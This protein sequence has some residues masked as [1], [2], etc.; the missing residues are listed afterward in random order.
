MI[1][2]LEETERLARLIA[3]RRG[4]SPE[5][6]VRDAVREHARAHGLDAP[7]RAGA[8]DRR[9]VDAITRRCASRPLRDPRSARAIL[10]EVWG[11]S[12]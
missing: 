8:M 3:A 4:S 11:R 1:R 6:V 12:A 9:R 7:R 2:V 10:D 5:D